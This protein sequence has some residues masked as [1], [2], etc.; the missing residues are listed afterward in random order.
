M[1]AVVAP[2]ATGLHVTENV[3]SAFGA[4]EAAGL[5]V[6]LKAAAADPLKLT[7]KFASVT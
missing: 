5:A 2:P 6:T 4:R 7:P 1:V 3:V